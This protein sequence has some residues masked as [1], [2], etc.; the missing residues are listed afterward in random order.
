MSS[1]DELVM[2]LMSATDMDFG[3]AIASLESSNWNLQQCMNKHFDTGAATSSNVRNNNG[4]GNGGGNGNNIDGDDDIRAP[5]L[6]RTEV[7]SHLARVAR[8]TASAASFNTNSFD[9]ARQSQRDFRAEG[10]FGNPSAA[11]SRSN[12]KRA[13]LAELF[14]PPT[15]LLFVGTYDEAIERAKA[16]KLWLVVNVQDVH[17]F[18]SQRLNRDTWSD[19]SVRAL[20]QASCVFL[21]LPYGTRAA[22]E[23]LQLYPAST[24]G[25]DATVSIAVIDPRTGERVLRW[26]GFVAHEEFCLR[27][28]DT[29]DRLPLDSYRKVAPRP[30]AAAARAPEVQRELTEEESIA[31]AIAASLESMP[32]SASNSASTA[33]VSTTQIPKRKA[34]EIVATERTTAATTTASTTMT[35][36][37]NEAVPVHTPKRRTVAAVEEVRVPL[38]SEAEA[39]A[40]ECVIMVRLLNGQRIKCGFA[41]S[42]TLADLHRYVAQHGFG[43]QGPPAEDFALTLQL[44]TRVYSG[45]QLE[46]VTMADAKLQGRALVLVTAL[47]PATP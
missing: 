47:V 45:A 43:E 2:Q 20:I 28:S 7:L 30:K 10:R 41:A 4:V 14:R 6:P 46:Q 23:F 40:C 22:S 8:P 12:S 9:I 39:N 5:I 37:S 26:Q 25:T 19:A 31:A 11:Q 44:P 24:A 17:E 18:D 27:L 38:Q 33:A 42:A 34:D 21:Q 3:T 16:K 29:I 32:A 36:M 15:D 1:R 13:K 35:S